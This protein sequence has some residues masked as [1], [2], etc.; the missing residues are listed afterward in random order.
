ML[1][2][3]RHGV[4]P[5]P[6]DSIDPCHYAQSLGRQRQRRGLPVSLDLGVEIATLEVDPTVGIGALGR[7][8]ILGERL[9]LPLHPC[10][11]RAVDVLVDDPR[12]NERRLGVVAHTILSPAR[13]TETV[14]LSL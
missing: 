9:R 11:S 5:P 2:L 1:G 14:V 6:L 10:K 3:D 12:R 4:T 7:V 13:N 8:D